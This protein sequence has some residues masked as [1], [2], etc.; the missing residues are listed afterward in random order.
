MTFLLQR[1]IRCGATLYKYLC[2]LDFKWLLCLWGSYQCTFYNDSCSNVQ[3]GNLCEIL[4]VIM[5]YDLKSFKKA[6]IM[7][8]D[9]SK[10]LGI[11]NASYP[12][13]YRDL[14]IKILLTV[15]VNFFHCCQF[16]NLYLI[17]HIQDYT[18]LRTSKC[19]YRIKYRL[20]LWFVQGVIA[21]IHRK[22]P[23]TGSSPVHGIIC[24]ISRLMHQC[25]LCSDM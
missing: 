17:P 14:F 4:H 7:E 25:F 3:L 12:S 5:I 19:P 2:R 8:Y 6:S 13:A 9:E 11:T 21:L 23:H 22:I 18:S 1:I 24:L 10:S 16:H 15:S 20:F